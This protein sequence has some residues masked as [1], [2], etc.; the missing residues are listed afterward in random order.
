LIAN[1]FV[2]Y[3][4]PLNLRLGYA[5]GFDQGGEDQIY[6]DVLFAF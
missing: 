5:H 6:L 2:G 4:L 1:L 3:F